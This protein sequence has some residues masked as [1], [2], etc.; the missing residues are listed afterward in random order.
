M[1]EAQTSGALLGLNR[2]Q[3]LVLFAAWL[4]WGFDVF[5][6]LLFNY[7]SPICVPALLGLDPADPATKTETLYVTAWL[8]SLLL[9]GWALG[10]IAFGQLTDRLGRTR[11]LLLTMLTYSLATAACALAPNLPTLALFRFIAS[12]GIGGEWAAGAALVAESLPKERRVLGGALLYTS[13]PMGLFLAT[14]VNDLFTRKLDRIAADPTLSWR[15]VFATGLLPALVALAIRTRVR[16]PELWQPSSAPRLGELWTAELRK[17]TLGGLSMAVI[18]L[19]TWWSCSA[20]IP[21]VAGNLSAGA[22]IPAGQTAAL[23][24]TGFITTATTAFNLGGLLGTLITIPAALY[25]GRRKMFLLYFLAGAASIHWTFGLDHTASVRMLSMFGVGLSVFGVFGAFSFYL[26]E[27][28]PTRLRGTGSGLCYNA[29]RIVTAA[30]PF[31]VGWVVRGGAAP[32]EVLSWVALVPLIGVVLV[33][34]GLVSE[35]R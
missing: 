6:G 32:L 21:V 13:A 16:E 2:Y 5:D 17:N 24:R 19:I 8:T 3:W 4:G 31:G 11:T 14:F 23:V 28:F 35:T 9:L 30:F 1:S 18:A 29:G 12:L 15:V 34:S 25:L 20:F 27:L 26:P 33:A 22:P 7:V 10:G